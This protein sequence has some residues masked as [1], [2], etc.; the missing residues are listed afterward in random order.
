VVLFTM[1]IQTL[2]NYGVIVTELCNLKSVFE[3]SEASEVRILET[4]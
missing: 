3:N 1:R 2:C 4:Q